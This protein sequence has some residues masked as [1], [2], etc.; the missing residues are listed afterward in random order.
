MLQIGIEAGLEPNDIKVK[1]SG[2][3]RSA[4]FRSTFAQF[5]GL[6]DNDI[7]FR[8]GVA[9]SERGAWGGANPNFWWA[10][11]STTKRAF[12]TYGSHGWGW[13]K[14]GDTFAELTLLD[15]K[16][17]SL[18]R[19][20]VLIDRA[21][22]DARSDP[23]VQT[24]TLSI[25]QTVE[26]T[27]ETSWER[28]TSLEVSAKVGVDAGPFSAETTATASTSWTQ[29]GSSSGTKTVAIKDEVTQEVQPGQLLLAGEVIQR[30]Q[31]H[32]E[33]TYQMVLDPASYIAC[34][35][36]GH[37]NHKKS[38]IETGAPWHVPGVGVTPWLAIPATKVAP[39]TQVVRKQIVTVDVVADSMGSVWPL[40]GTLAADI[41][42]AVNLNE[43]VVLAKTDKPV[44]IEIEAV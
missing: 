41:D 31:A 17:V 16:L 42:R 38:G 5:C 39:H 32:L 1:A 22:W 21:I 25:D 26:Q 24:R 8:I 10:A 28:T 20:P 9:L 43:Q 34:H 12:A 44:D 6:D 33:L 27:V 35:T 15:A 18:S 37:T 23:D 14:P 30:S 4:L 7:K 11:A 13:A 29:A 36:T 19:Q 2:S 40:D 3:D